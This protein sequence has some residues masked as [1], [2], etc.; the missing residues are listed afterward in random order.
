MD[1]KNYIIHLDSIFS[2]KEIKKIKFKKYDFF[3]LKNGILF[4]NENNIE[5]NFDLID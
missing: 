3:I 1:K 2:M 5:I 4:L